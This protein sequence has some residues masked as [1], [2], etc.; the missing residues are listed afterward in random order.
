[1][2]H[3]QNE[4][5]LSDEKQKQQLREL[6]DAMKSTWEEKARLSKQHEIDR[7]RLEQEQL[8]LSRRTAL[9]KER[10]W[11]MLEDKGDWELTISHIKDIV[12]H[13]KFESPV[14]TPESSMSVIS[15]PILD[16]LASWNGSLKGVRRSEET[17]EEHTTIVNV[18]RSSLQKDFFSLFSGLRVS[19]WYQKQLPSH[20]I[21][22]LMAVVY[23]PSIK[24]HQ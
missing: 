24:H 18:Y 10:N 9:Q 21:C 5:N 15:K 19:V 20:L 13:A 11:Q 7:L 23:L 17:I 1:M 22:R 3:M 2:V 16:T 6:E 14:E 4:N 8:E 12:L